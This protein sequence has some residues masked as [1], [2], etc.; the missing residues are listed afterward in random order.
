MP[1]VSLP[2]TNQEIEVREGE[3]IYDALHDQGIELPHGCLSGS[4]GA[5]R[6][7][8]ISGEEQLIPPTFVEMDTV[9]AVKE[10]LAQ[11]RGSD[12]LQNKVIRL[13]CRA[14][15]TG[16]VCIRPLK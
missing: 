6:I 12:F 13:S 2:D 4:C 3:V 8:V 10:E 14:K 1:R 16:D 15:V 11:L 7:E 5:C 9:E